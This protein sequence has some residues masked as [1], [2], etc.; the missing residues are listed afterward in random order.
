MDLDASH[1]GIDNF[2]V[3]YSLCVSLHHLLILAPPMPRLNS[4]IQILRQQI[5][6]WRQRT[7]YHQSHIRRLGMYHLPHLYLPPCLR[8][9]PYQP[10]LC[11]QLNA[12]RHA[13]LRVLLRDYSL[14]VSITSCHKV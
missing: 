13:G 2:Y 11:L 5:Q 3:P 14:S 8:L 7:M 4:E 12:V 6:H 10:L 1:C 9:I